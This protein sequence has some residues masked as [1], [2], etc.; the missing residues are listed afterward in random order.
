M[1]RCFDAVDVLAD[2]LVRDDGVS[3]GL[4]E[5]ADR[6]A[7]GVRVGGARVGKG[8]HSDARPRRRGLLRRVRVRVRVRVRGHG[9]VQTMVSAT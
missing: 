2:D 9:Q 7:A 6:L 3:G 5:L 1:E 4:D 8:Q